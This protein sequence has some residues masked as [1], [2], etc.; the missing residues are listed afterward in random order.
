MKKLFIIILS[1]VSLIS[2]GQTL[3]EFTLADS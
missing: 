3:K 2:K 1:L